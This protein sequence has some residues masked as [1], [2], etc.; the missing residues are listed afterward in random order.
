LA[1]GTYGGENRA[2]RDAARRLSDLRDA[3]VLRA[4]VETLVAERDAALEPEAFEPVVAELRR[5]RDA[6]AGAADGEGRLAEVAAALRD[7][8]ERSRRWTLEKEGADAVVGGLRR[9]YRRGHKAMQR[10]FAK[11]SAARF[12]EWRKRS[13]YGMYH[14]RLLRDAWR[15]PLDAWEEAQH[16]LSDVLGDEHD[17]AVLEG[18]LS[19]L[20]APDDAAEV[21]RGLVEGRRRALRCRA[22]GL[23]MRLYAERPEACARRLAAYVEAWHAETA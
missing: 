9:T 1:S 2:L 23:G 6:E 5:R 14:L 7:A 11:P 22:H 12:H 16:A 20:P 8:R 19:T 15:G 18:E 3:E 21:L 10:A 17:L 13:K 4:C